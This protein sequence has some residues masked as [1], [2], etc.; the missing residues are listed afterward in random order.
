VLLTR[1]S[2]AILP[3]KSGKADRVGAPNKAGF[4]QT[5]CCRYRALQIRTIWWKSMSLRRSHGSKDSTAPQRTVK[6]I[7]HSALRHLRAAPR[8]SGEPPALCLHDVRLFEA[9]RLRMQCR[10]SLPPDI[11]RRDAIVRKLIKRFNK[12]R[13]GI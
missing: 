3:H 9:S 1:R 11:R 7:R 8:L 5:P 4:P 13:S 6:L 12:W 2:D 10:P